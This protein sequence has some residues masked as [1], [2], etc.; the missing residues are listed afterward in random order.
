M[1]AGAC[2]I[3]LVTL[4]V[5]ADDGIMPQTQEHLDICRLLGI[6]KGVIVITKTDLVEKEWVELIKE[7][8]REFVSATFLQDAP[9]IPV[10]SLRGDGIPDL[11]TE[12]DLMVKQ[13]EERYSNKIFRLPIDRVFSMKGFGTVV[14]GTVISGKVQAGD[15]IVILPQGIKTKIRGIQVYNEEI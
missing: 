12:L 4:I 6:K 15:T 9:I 14:T 10:S 1:V 2:G 5:A 13:M 11:I 3:D 8:V 7:E